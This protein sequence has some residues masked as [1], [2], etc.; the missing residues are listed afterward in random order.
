MQPVEVV[1]EMNR[2]EALA[3]FGIIV[4]LTPEKGKEPWEVYDSSMRRSFTKTQESC[5]E[6]GK[7]WLSQDIHSEQH[8]SSLTAKQAA[9]IKTLFD[10]ATA[11]KL[12]A[13][14]CWQP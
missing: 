4:T 5:I 3:E 11:G 9:A 14:C 10:T 7:E 12:L 13:Y 6:Q 8:H 1:A 2:L